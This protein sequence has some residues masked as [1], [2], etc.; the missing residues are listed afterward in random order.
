MRA[1]QILGFRS[2]LQTALRRPWQTYRDGTI[3]Y[4]QLKTG[5]KRH[6]LTTKQGNKNYYKGTGSSGIGTLD[7]RGRY[8]IN[9]DKVRTYVVPA[10]LNVSTLKPL[11][12]PK[13]PKFIQKVEG[14]DDGF[15][16]PQLALHSAINFIENGSSMEDLDLEEIGYVEKITN[17][18]LQ[19]KETTTED[20][21]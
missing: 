7:T 8:H 6:R 3:W 21:D 12:S 18:K 4:G 19:K 10:G 5:S 20:D 9:W 17:P 1:S 2:S 11:V 15:K 14:Y 16:S 13:S